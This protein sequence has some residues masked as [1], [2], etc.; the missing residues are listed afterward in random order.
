MRESENLGDTPLYETVFNPL[1]NDA[2]RIQKVYVPDNPDVRKA[3]GISDDVTPV[4]IDDIQSSTQGELYK[5]RKYTPTIV[6]TYYDKYPLNFDRLRDIGYI[7]KDQ[8]LLRES[9]ELNLSRNGLTG[10]SSMKHPLWFA[11]AARTS[12][13]YMGAPSKLVPITSSQ[14]RK[15]RS[16]QEQALKE[17][18][19][20]A[21]RDIN[22]APVKDL[23]EVLEAIRIRNSSLRRQQ[24][25]KSLLP[26][27]A[28]ELDL[29][30]RTV[31][32]LLQS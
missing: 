12:W 5:G 20:E 32:V 21:Q 16:I 29:P 15:Q 25:I 30:E 19:D 8:D 24:R 18:L 2:P 11:P 1:S 4:T 31:S 10:D 26:A 13:G 22:N 9:L 17:I 27:L 3:L 6:E 7:D 28:K 23:K 14:L